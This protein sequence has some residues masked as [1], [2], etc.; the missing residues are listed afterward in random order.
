MG[1]EAMSKNHSALVHGWRDRTVPVKPST[2][3]GSIATGSSSSSGDAFVTPTGASVGEGVTDG[4]AVAGVVVDAGAPAAVG[5]AAVE[6][7]AEVVAGG[8]WMINRATCP[9]SRCGRQ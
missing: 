6:G 9:R 7:G 8:A 3:F 5:A 2:E 4:I 1:A